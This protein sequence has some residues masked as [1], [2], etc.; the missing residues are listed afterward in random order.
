MIRNECHWQHL[1]RVIHQVATEK[2][3]PLLT[4]IVGDLRLCANRMEVMTVSTCQVMVSFTVCPVGSKVVQR[5][6]DVAG[7][8]T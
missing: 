3:G 7:A 2:V 1:D 4:E 6:G 5:T 8:A